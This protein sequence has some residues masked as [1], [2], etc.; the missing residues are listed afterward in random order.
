M[1]QRC[2]VSIPEAVALQQRVA[3]SPHSIDE[4]IR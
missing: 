2:I 4:V 3:P 1:K